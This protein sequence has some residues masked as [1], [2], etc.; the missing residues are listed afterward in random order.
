[1]AHA[2]AISIG[3]CSKQS[4]ASTLK[5]DISTI[6]LLHCSII[7]YQSKLLNADKAINL[8]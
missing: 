7:S 4:T 6:A 1:L 8:G 2:L 5:S 3:Q